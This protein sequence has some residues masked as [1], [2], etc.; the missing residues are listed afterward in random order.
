MRMNSGEDKPKGK[1]L[2]LIMREH[3]RIRCNYGREEINRHAKSRKV[4]DLR[5]REERGEEEGE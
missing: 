5:G 2:W 4:E 1:C 3:K